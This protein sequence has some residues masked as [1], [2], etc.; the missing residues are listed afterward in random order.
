MRDSDRGINS[1]SCTN[2]I[3]SFDEATINAITDISSGRRTA[4][5]EIAGRDSYAAAKLALES[6]EYDFFIPT[7]A[8]T[9]TEFGSLDAVLENARRLR[10]FAEEELG[11]PSFEVQ[12]ISSPE[13]WHASAGRFLEYHVLKYGFSPVCIACHMY[14]HACRIPLAIRTKTRAIVS[15]ERMSHDTRIKINQSREAVRAY[16]NV[17]EEMGVKF[18][19]PLFEISSGEHIA[20]IAGRD[21]GEAER[22]MKC[23]LEKNFVSPQGEVRARVDMIERY[24]REFLLPF[25][26]RVLRIICI[27]HARPDYAKIS[28]DVVRGDV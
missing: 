13:W 14:L 28:N 7:V 24:L 5:I 12:V 19:T 20:S 16:R 9:G 21:W 22:Q 3:T 6:G 11:I 18:H 25:T 10:K 1:S 26:R 27:E 2:N 4:L 8:R 15:G 23:V 17:L